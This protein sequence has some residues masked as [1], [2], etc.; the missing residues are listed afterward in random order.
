[1]LQKSSKSSNEGDQM[2]KYANIKAGEKGAWLSII[3]YIV[4]SVVKLMVGWRSGSEALWADGLNNFTDIIASIAVLI[5]L[6]ISQKPPDH[7]HRYGHFRAETIASLV[8]SLIM[9]GIGIQVVAQSVSHFF[10]GTIVAPSMTAAWTAAICSVIMFIVYRVNRMLAQR[11]QNQAL[12]AAAL[13]NRSDALVSAGA[14]VGIIGASMGIV[15]LD[16]LAAAIVGVVICIT[17]WGIFREATHALTDGFD[18]T[19]LNEFKDTVLTI[20]GVESIIDMRARVHGNSILL[21]IIIGVDCNLNVTQSH[22][23]SDEIEKTLLEKHR[24]DHV[25]IHVEPIQKN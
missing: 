19:K 8:A 10:N 6:R 4:L 24:L 14:F 13:D 23:I 11:I 7:D 18:E 3:A 12:M 15:W 9:F 20:P 16:P 22:D 17:A 5:G 25:H 1:M 2:D 21:D